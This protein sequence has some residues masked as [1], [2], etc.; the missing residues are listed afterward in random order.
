MGSDENTAS[1]CLTLPGK[2]LYLTPLL[3]AK[4]FRKRGNKDGAIRA[5]YKLAENGLGEVVEYGGTKGTTI[6]SEPGL[7]KALLDF[8]FSNSNFIK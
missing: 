3:N 5:F 8:I 1:Y 7:M 2:V 6:V 4:K